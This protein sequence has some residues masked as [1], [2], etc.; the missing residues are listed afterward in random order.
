MGPRLFDYF[1]EYDG[2]TFLRDLLAG[3]TVAIVAL[4]LAIGFAIASGVTPTQGLWTAIVAG[5]LI[6]AFG[7]SRVQIGG[8]T[9]A[10]VPIIAGIVAAQGYDGLAVATLMAGV[11]LIA[12]G[13]LRLGAL[14]KYIPYPVIAG[15]TS[16]IAVI[17]FIGQLRELL[18]LRVALPV[19]ALPQ[20]GTLAGH[21]GQTQW[22]ALLIGL[23]TIAIMT[24]WPQRWRVLPSAIFALIGLT[25][26]A[27]FLAFPIETIGSRFGGIPQGFPSLRLPAISFGRIQ[28]LMLPA[29]TIAMLGAI[30]SLLSAM[31][32]DGMIGRRHD[33]NQELIGQG[34]ANLVSPLCGGIPATG[35]IARTATNVRSGGRTPIAGMVH[36][37]TLLVIVL[38]A[39]PVA[40]FIPLA[41]FS[42]VLI[43]VAWRMGEWH[44]FGIMARGPR[45]D[46]WVLLVTFAL[47]VAFGLTVAVGLGLLIAAALFIRQMEAVTQI[48]LVTPESDLEV[49]GE[50][51]R[52]KE[53]PPGV[54]VYRFEG[55]LFFGVA[56]KLEAALERSSA[57]PPVVIFRMRNVPAIDATG[58]RV[59]NLVREKFERRGTRMVFSGVQPQPMKVLFEG[60]LVDTIGLENI[61]ANIDAA[62]ERAHA[63]LAS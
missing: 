7:G 15:F 33:S 23:T 43:V 57:I 20:L 3:I 13:A 31:V 35:A 19:N 38:V 6:S 52:G 40:R 18:G 60:G 4:P 45:G 47:T 14:I 26:L 30:E 22:Q 49:G 9:G 41:T 2:N 59:L 50:S 63:I 34:L 21:L 12:I 27:Q 44:N 17:I 39:A 16:G 55:P 54:L 1:Q 62:L 61:C 42:G 46:F 10:F 28:M 25:I 56:E 5:F 51:V 37:A 53:I 24:F 8:P 36:S 29:F 58:L 32:A 48:H 11:M